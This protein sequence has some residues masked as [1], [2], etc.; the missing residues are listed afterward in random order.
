MAEKKRM[1]MK[2]LMMKFEAMDDAR[3]E[4]EE[5]AREI[6]L[7]REFGPPVDCV[8]TSWSPWSDCSATCGKAFR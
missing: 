2:Q 1:M 8:V 4:A 7:R 6:R 3:A 5:E